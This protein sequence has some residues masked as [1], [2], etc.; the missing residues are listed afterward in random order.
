M[1]LRT[2][3]KWCE[4]LH[5]AHGAARREDGGRAKRIGK[6]RR[7]GAAQRFPMFIE[8]KLL[9]EK[10]I[11]VER[12]QRFD[13]T[14]QAFC[15]IGKHTDR[16]PR[17]EGCHSKRHELVGCIA[18]AALPNGVWCKGRRG[19]SSSGSPPPGRDRQRNLRSRSHERQRRHWRL[20]VIAGE[21]D[22]A[23]PILRGRRIAQAIA[24][25]RFELVPLAGHSST[26]EQPEIVTTLIRNFLAE[27]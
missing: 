17:V 11:D 14:R 16:E 3:E 24:G 2:G 9:H 18:R 27:H 22:E 6:L 13:H 25:A 23:I 1:L 20:L 21:H 12:R 10:K 15:G 19:K 5:R 7:R 8:P 26:L 4:L